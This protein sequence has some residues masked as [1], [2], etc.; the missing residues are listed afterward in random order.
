MKLLTRR[1]LLVS[2]FAAATVGGGAWVWRRET[3]PTFVPVPT[4]TGLGSAE[5]PFQL[6]VAYIR[7][8]DQPE[9]AE[10]NLSDLLRRTRRVVLEHLGIHV[11]F[12]VPVTL[13]IDDAF[14][15]VPQH[16]RNL[17]DQT[18]I[19]L[20]EFLGPQGAA[21][22]ASLKESVNESLKHGHSSFNDFVEF[23]RPLLAVER[24][25]TTIDEL[26]AA[27]S[28]TQVR[29]I[30]SMEKEK[31]FS[32]GVR[33]RY[34]AFT[35]WAYLQEAKLRFDVLITNQLIAGAEAG[36]AEIHSSLRGGVTG[37]SAVSNASANHG[38]TA[39]ASLYPFFSDAAWLREMRDDTEATPYELVE[40]EAFFA[41]LLAHE[42]GHMLLHLD[43]PFG[44]PSCVMAPAP[45]L[46]Y[47]V[48]ARQLDA[49]RCRAA[50][51]TAMKPGAYKYW[52]VLPLP[53]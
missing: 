14:A 52:K 15:R 50:K 31:A 3:S 33:R 35:H 43:H 6:S 53:R 11:E 47:R 18:R 16:T 32:I 39:V 7:N 27:V 9:F 36:A 40:R 4:R 37:G 26:T 34:H 30:R 22:R 29:R 44:V 1:N 10:A 45:L 8:P 38:V 28:E 42:L 51:S 19:E 5:K 24:P 23:V 41:S 13:L 21:L 2:A 49:A 20:D 46:K 17:I 48:H 25:L 12:A